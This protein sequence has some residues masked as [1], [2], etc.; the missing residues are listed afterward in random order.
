MDSPG[1]RGIRYPRER[2]KPMEPEE[3]EYDEH[4]DDEGGG[5]AAAAVADEDDNDDRKNEVT[6]G[7]D[8]VLD[9]AELEQLQEEAERMKGL[10]NKHMAAQVSQLSEVWA[11]QCIENPLGGE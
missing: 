6:G 8:A 2:R 4:P 1:N 7:E 9:L 3:C 11:Q 10:G 5:G